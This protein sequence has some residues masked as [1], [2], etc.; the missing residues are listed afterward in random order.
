MTAVDLTELVRPGDTVHWQQ[1]S[2]EPLALTSALVEQR[3]SLGGIDVFL[4]LGLTQTL[5]PEHAD[6]I[7]FRSIGGYGT[8][9]RLARAG[10]LEIVPSHVSALPRLVAEGVIPVDVLF[11][12]VSP[13][14]ADGFHSL[15]VVADYV[16][17]ALDRARVVV[18]QVNDRMPR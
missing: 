5:Q 1:A 10:V 11:L 7:R 3:A 9:A 15:G 13:C 17:V 6:H 18:A 4:G 16:R 8:N 14:D 2:G 12:H